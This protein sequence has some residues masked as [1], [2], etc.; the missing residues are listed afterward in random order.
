MNKTMTIITSIAAGLVIFLVFFGLFISISSKNF[1]SAYQ[2]DYISAIPDSENYRISQTK[3]M[4]SSIYSSSSSEIFDM[5]FLDYGTYV[6]VETSEKPYSTF[7]LDVDTASYTMAR[8]YILRGV[9]P[10]TESIRAEEFINYFNY[11]YPNPSDNFGITTHLTTSPFDN[12]LYYLSIG[13]KAREIADEDRKPVHL[14]F[15]IDVS[16]SMNTGNRLGIVKKSLK[17]LVDNL[18]EYDKIA[19][20]KYGNSAE[21][22]LDYTSLDKREQIFSVI[23]SLVASGS[24]N[25]DQGLKVGYEHAASNLLEDGINRVVLL[26]DGVANVGET[27]PE[28]MINKLKIYKDMGISITSIGVGLGNYNDVFLEQIA[29]KGDGNYYYID[30]IDE[31]KKVFYEQLTGMFEIIGKDVRVQV[32]FNSEKIY[33]YRLIGYENRQIADENFRNETGEG[34]S[35]GAGHQVTAIYELLLKNESSSNNV[36]KIVL[37]Y[38]NANTSVIEE[39]S[40]DISQDSIDFYDS[41]NHVK[42]SISVA[43]FAQILKHTAPPPSII[44]VYEILENLELTDDSEQNLLDL[45]YNTKRLIELKQQ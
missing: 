10:P 20:V 45:V 16:G 17:F 30:D 9:L 40:K 41:P 37:R 22:I 2:L 8:T 31:A 13:I 19:I 38:V 27:D 5:Y 25:T 18:N 36:G 26:S 3:T 12:N 34:G 33:K 42:L 15:V 4:D 43:R 23:D 21:L 35:V 28:S 11:N 39:I 44:S 29:N 24:T 1:S 14:M 32:E 6:F 7:G